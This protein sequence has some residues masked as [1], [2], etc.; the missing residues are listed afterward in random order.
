MLIPLEHGKP[1]VFGG[2]GNE[3]GVVQRPDGSLEIVAV[4]EAGLDTLL[5]H[6][7]ARAD[8]GLAFGLSRLAR[9]PYEPTPIGVFR[10]VERPEYGQ[11]MSDQIVDAQAKRGLGDVAALLRSGSSWTVS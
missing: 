6:D 5:V 4:A 7:E 1:I 3:R 8:P 10:A 9:G 2:E 11:Q